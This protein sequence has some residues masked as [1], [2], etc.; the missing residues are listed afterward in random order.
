[1][2]VK[3]INSGKRVVSY[4]Y[5][6]NGN[7]IRTL[8]EDGQQ[9]RL[10]YDD[11]GRI[12]SVIQRE[13]IYEIMILEEHY[14]YDKAGN[15]IEKSKREKGYGYSK[16]TTYSYDPLNQLTQVVEGKKKIGYTYDEVG[17]RIQETR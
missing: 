2:L 17:N 3:T 6:G 4:V 16:I 13:G 7:L 15:C 14:T 5:D 8:D 11:A 10:G 1:M 12:Q 9:V